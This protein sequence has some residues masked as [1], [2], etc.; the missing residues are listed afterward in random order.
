MARFS[1]KIEIINHFDS[2]VNRIDIDIDSC[3]EKFNH[4]LVKDLQQSYLYDRI[5]AKSGSLFAIKV[6]KDSLY[7]SQF[8]SETSKVIDYLKQIR[9]RTIEE[10][11]KEQQET[12]EKYN[13]NSERFKSE[14]NEGKSLEQLRKE[15]FDEKFYFQI[16]IKQSIWAFNVFT[17]VTDF[18]MSQSDIE[19]L[20]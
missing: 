11:K 1:P 9:M 2:L 20:E 14:I 7:I 3:L 16:Q 10:L 19:S 15:I 18:Y 17:I 12:L 4:Q 8:W 5:K 13:V 6:Y